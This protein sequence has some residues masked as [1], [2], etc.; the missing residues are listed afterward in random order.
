MLITIAVSIERKPDTEPETYWMENMLP[1]CIYDEDFELWY[2]LWNPL[3]NKI[4]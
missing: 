4:T 3:T 2:L 1:S